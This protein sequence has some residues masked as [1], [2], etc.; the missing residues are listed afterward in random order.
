MNPSHRA[1]LVPSLPCLGLPVT[2]VELGGSDTRGVG[3][4]PQGTAKPD[5]TLRVAAIEA[6]EGHITIPLHG[7]A[8]TVA[9]HGQGSG[10]MVRGFGRRS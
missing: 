2:A 5:Q 9:A 8:K 6:P 3:T 10:A 4:G 7:D 1:A